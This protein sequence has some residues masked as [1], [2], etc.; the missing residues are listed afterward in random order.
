MGK[1]VDGAWVGHAAA[2]RSSS[3]APRLLYEAVMYGCPEGMLCE[4]CCRKLVEMP[5]PMP[6]GMTRLAL[7][8]RLLRYVERSAFDVPQ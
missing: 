1:P 5:P 2:A 6:T 3:T 7:P 8:F 4:S